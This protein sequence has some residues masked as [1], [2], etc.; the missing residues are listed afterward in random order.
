MVKNERRLKQTTLYIVELSTKKG[1]RGLQPS[2]ETSPKFREVLI[3][4]KIQKKKI[5]IQ[6]M[7]DYKN[8]NVE[9]A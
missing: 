9:K 5:E 6:I 8:Q 7:P 1:L 2:A 3:Y 4:Y